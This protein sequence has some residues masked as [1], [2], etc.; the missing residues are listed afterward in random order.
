MSL[1]CG[2]EAATG[3]AVLSCAVKQRLQHCETQLITLQNGA[4]SIPIPLGVG[5]WVHCDHATQVRVQGLVHF[6]ESHFIALPGLE[7][8][9]VCQLSLRPA[10]MLLPLR[11]WDYESLP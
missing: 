7:H 2:L 11:R 3:S 10:A 8:C 5:R 6:F 9:W 4:P 1:A